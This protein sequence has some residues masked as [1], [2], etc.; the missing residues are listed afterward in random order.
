MTANRT[1][2]KQLSGTSG[3]TK[4]SLYNRIKECRYLYLMLFPFILWFVVFAYKPM[5]GLLIAFKEYEPY[6]GVMGSDWVGLENFRLFFTGPYFG[7]TFK[8]TIVINLYSL[9]FSFPAP[10]ILAIMLNEVKQRALKKTIQTITYLPYFIS[11]VVIAGMVSNFLAPEHG[12]LNLIIERFGGEKTYFLTRPEYF[13]TIFIT[14]NIWK[15]TGFNAIVYLAALSSIDAE[16]YEAV[17]I[18]GAGKLRQLWHVTLPGILSTM[19][20]MF[21]MR[22]GQILEV[23]HEAILLLY[24]SAIYETADVISTYVYRMGILGDQQGLAAAVGLFNSVVSLALVM[25]VNRISRHVSEVSL[26]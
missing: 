9:L 23:G 26:W 7:R 10:V 20:I 17:R 24:Q 3:S 18:D 1:R 22:V 12:L 8:N 13:R 11:I 16:L 19:V 4:T 6:K 5:Y 21:I 14:M 2:L 25:I 15:D